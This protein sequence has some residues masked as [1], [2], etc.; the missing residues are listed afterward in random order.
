MEQDL[1]IEQIFS[2]KTFVKGNREYKT[3]KEYLEPF[4]EKISGIAPD[5]SVKVS[6]MVQNAEIDK[7]VN[8]AYARVL[9]E[10]SNVKMKSELGVYPTYGIVVGLDPIVPIYKVYEGTT[11]SA[12][13]N[14]CV[15]NA[16]SLFSG[17]IFD[18]MSQGYEIVDGW[19]KD[20]EKNYGEYLDIQQSMMKREVEAADVTHVLGKLLKYGV[21]NKYFGTNPVIAATKELYNPSS[22]YY[23]GEEGT[24]AWN[25]YNAVTSHLSTKADIVDK[26]SKTLLLSKFFIN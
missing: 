9:I 1:T 23:A 16:R 18:G 19:I 13:T 17:Q 8:T 20:W 7:S 10:A 14:L 24:T 26:A 4:I 12:C 25:M 3:P 6:G 21:E 5:I 2:S 11:V 22:V 15:F